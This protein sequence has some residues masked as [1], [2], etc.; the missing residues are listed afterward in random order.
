MRRM[1]VTI[2]RFTAEPPDSSEIR[3]YLRHAATLVAAA[4]LETA[5]RRAMLRRAL[6]WLHAA[7]RGLEQMLGSPVDAACALEPTRPG[8]LPEGSQ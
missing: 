6:S 3:H 5:A 1:D 8:T 4:D 2:L 7:V